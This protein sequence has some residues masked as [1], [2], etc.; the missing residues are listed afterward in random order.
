[1]ENGMKRRR[2]P[3][4]VRVPTMVAIA[5]QPSYEGSELAALT[6]FRLGQAG[7]QQYDVLADC[8]NM[9][10]LG[11]DRRKDEGA[12]AVATAAGI[13]LSNIKDRHAKTGR[14]G[15]T[16]EEMKALHVLVDVSQDFWK[17]QGGGTFA[18]C[19]AALE[20]WCN[21]QIEERRP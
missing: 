3:R 4:P 17:R 10:L 9:L 16:G 18:E 15:T 6:L 8:R 5:T 13:A 19:H 1:M 7:K 11:A 12:F 14:M 20:Q 2:I 21:S